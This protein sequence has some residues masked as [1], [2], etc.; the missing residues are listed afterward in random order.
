MLYLYK[1]VL[2][3][4]ASSLDKYRTVTF[5]ESG[6]PVSVSLDLSDPLMKKF[7]ETLMEDFEDTLVS[8]E[9]Q[10]EEAISLDEL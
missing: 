8:L 2:T 5:N 1:N 10:D 6:K 3:M 7:Y 9:R 4:T